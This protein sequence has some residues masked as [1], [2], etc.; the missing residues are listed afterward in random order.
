[1]IKNIELLK[2]EPQD[3]EKIKTGAMLHQRMSNIQFEVMCVKDEH[4]EMRTIQG[5]CLSNNYASHDALMDRTVRLFTPF[6]KGR[7]IMVDIIPFDHLAQRASIE[8]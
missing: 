5:M 1:M 4:I 2:L 7:W 3:L 8:N 6:V